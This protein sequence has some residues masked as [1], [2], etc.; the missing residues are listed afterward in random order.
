MKALN[1][2]KSVWIIL[3]LM[4]L[5]SS[6]IRAILAIKMGTVSIIYD[7]LLYWDI[8]KSIVDK[9]SI[10]MRGLIQISYIH[11][12]YPGYICLK[13]LIWHIMQL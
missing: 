2:E 3:G 6:V 7:E 5:C 13:T 11:C 10:L 9:T 1:K 4:C 8:S 12:L